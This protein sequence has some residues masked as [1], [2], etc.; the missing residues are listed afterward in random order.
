MELERSQYYERARQV[1]EAGLEHIAR[2][3]PDPDDWDA[4]IQGDA[5]L[6]LRLGL[7][8]MLLGDASEGRNHLAI[9]L[10]IA[11]EGGLPWIETHAHVALGRGYLQDGRIRL[12]SAHLGT[13][14]A[15]LRTEP[16]PEIEREAV[17]ASAM[18]AFEE[19]RNEQAELLWQEALTLAEGDPA[20]VARC[21]IGLANRHLRSGDHERAQE[22]LLE[23]L[24]TSRQ[25][26]DRILEGRVLNNIGL[27]HS[28]AGRQEEALTYYRSALELREGIGYTR[29]V[30]VNHHNIGDV[31]FQNGDHAKAWVAFHRSRELALEI[32]W[33]R[34]VALNEV[35]LAYL[36]AAAGR[37]GLDKLRA[38]IDHARSVG[39]AEI[40][41]SGLWLAGRHLLEQGETDEARACLEDAAREARTFGLQPMVELI[42]DLLGDIDEPAVSSTD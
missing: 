6:H 20:A 25:A 33:E 31:H 4:R 16:D 28:W 35:Y 37:G 22:L 10:D 19:G 12:A 38:S 9:A 39:D 32:G 17:E 8:G 7:V 14:R 27:V 24:H 26:G 40:L 11:S 1:Y 29:G 3:T 21:Q 36:D 42:E 2:A 30:V 5:M 15:L 23:A 18:L 41:T 34:G 13:A